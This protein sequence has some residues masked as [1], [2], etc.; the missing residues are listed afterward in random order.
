[1]DGNQEREEIKALCAELPTS[2]ITH[3]NSLWYGHNPQPT[4]KRVMAAGLTLQHSATIGWRMEDG[5]LCAT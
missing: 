3:G 2:L 4:V 1:M 5:P